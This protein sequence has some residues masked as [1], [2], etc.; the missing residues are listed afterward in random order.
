M[1]LHREELDR[2]GC[3]SPDCTHDHSVLFLHGRCHPSANV[4]AA[5]HKK[6]GVLEIRCGRCTTLVAEI[7]VAASQ[8]TSAGE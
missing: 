8:R 3:A 7:A 6:S 4:T 1:I 2:Q 5:Y